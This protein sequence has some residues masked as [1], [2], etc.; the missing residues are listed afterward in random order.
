MSGHAKPLSPGLAAPRAVG[1]L[2]FPGLLAVLAVV[3][4]WAVDPG[5]IS[6]PACA[7]YRITGLHCPGCGATR[8]THQLLHGEL[9]PALRYNGLWVLALPV[10]VYAVG[11]EVRRFTRGRPLPGDL[12]RNRWFWVGAVAVALLFGLLRNVPVYPFM[13]LAPPG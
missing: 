8:A 4:I 11:S 6:W 12:V 5:R 2:I 9:I 7:L 13:L 1:R 10:A 3:L